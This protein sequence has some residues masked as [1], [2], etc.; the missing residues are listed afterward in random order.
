MQGSTSSADA[1]AAPDLGQQ[2]QTGPTDDARP[3]AG[4]PYDNGD[5]TPPD[6]PTV[7]ARF[8][9]TQ[10]EQAWLDKATDGTLTGWVRDA[11]GQVYKYTDVD[12]W[13]TDVDDAGMTPDSSTASA[14]ASDTSNDGDDTPDDSTQPPDQ[15][16]APTS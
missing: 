3:W 5:E 16:D 13:A 8:A 15:S 9:D 1:A 10:G 6:A 7:T 14:Q 2:P 4:D 12:T 11:S